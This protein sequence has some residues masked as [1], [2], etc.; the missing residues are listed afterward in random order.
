MIFK[1]KL[2]RL[3]R[4]SLYLGSAITAVILL[5]WL[6]GIGE[7]LSNRS[8]DLLFWWRGPIEP[9]VPVVIVAIDNESFNEMPERWIWPRD[10]HGK[11]IDKIMKGKPKA[12]AFDMLFTEPTAHDPRQDAEFAAACRRSGCVILGAELVQVRDKQFE[13][14]EFKL[15]IKLLLS[16]I[17]SPGV[18]NTPKD[19]DAF[20]RRSR[21]MWRVNE[22]RHYSLA[23]EAL[24][25]YS[26]VGKGE[27]NYE[28]GWLEFG[29]RRIPL[30]NDDNMLINYCGPAKTFKT[31]PYY[32]VFKGMTDP[33]IFKDAIVFVGASAESLHDTFHTPTTFEMVTGENVS[34]VMPGVEIHANV[35]D[36]I[37]TGR[38][39]SYSSWK[40]GFPA[41]D[42]RHADQ[43]RGRTRENMGDP[44]DHRRFRRRPAGIHLVPVRIPTA[45]H[46]IPVSA[47][48][49]CDR[50][51]GVHRLAGIP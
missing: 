18:V 43:H 4:R 51:P 45:I 14:Q 6:A 27:I 23:M 5:F 28:K 37:L 40:A 39:L 33:A 29:D 30:D 49:A 38:Y 35:I 41:G 3:E 11:L 31:I 34:T 9:T 50:V 24:R 16:S 17:F 48:H 32:Q 13:Y 19:S 46:R 47:G 36:T 22:E 7:S 25:K 21:L 10:F 8:M 20:V 44:A 2:S 1:T 15:P 26:G 12:I 42:P